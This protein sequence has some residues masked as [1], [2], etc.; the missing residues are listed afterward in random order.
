MARCATMAVIW[1][2][3]APNCSAQRF[4]VIFSEQIAERRLDQII[5]AQTL[6]AFQA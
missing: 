5:A 4:P 2:A 6:Y 3:D 1:I